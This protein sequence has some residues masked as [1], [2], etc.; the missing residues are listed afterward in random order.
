MDSDLRVVSELETYVQP[1]LPS[2][3]HC[4]CFTESLTSPLRS[5]L[6][7]PASFN[8]AEEASRKMKVLSLKTTFLGNAPWS[9]SRLTA[10]PCSRKGRGKTVTQTPS[11]IS[12]AEGQWFSIRSVKSPKEPSTT[13][14]DGLT[15]LVFMSCEG[16]RM[17]HRFQ[18]R[19]TWAAKI[20]KLDASSFTSLQTIWGGSLLT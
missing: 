12:W 13:R 16:G 11:K 14:G 7:P 18:E 6:P 8:G 20:T 1:L 9:P 17:Y 3:Q 4:A 19:K 15:P 10:L 2:Q 5:W